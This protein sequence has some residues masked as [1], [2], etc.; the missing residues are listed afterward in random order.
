[1]EFSVR[2]SDE[3]S[4][5]FISYGSSRDQYKIV[6]NEVVDE[7]GRYNTEED[8]AEYPTLLTVSCSPRAD[9]IRRS[10][11]GQ[12]ELVFLRRIT[13]NGNERIVEYG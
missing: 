1:M 11:S 12:T 10:L 13:F 6:A 3:R 4:D 9:D 7:E 5:Y 8:F 2:S